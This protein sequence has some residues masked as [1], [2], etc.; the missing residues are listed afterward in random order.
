MATLCQASLSALFFLQH[1]LTSCLCHTLVILAIFQTFSLLLYLLWWCLIRDLW[2]Y[3]CGCFGC[4]N[5]GHL[6]RWTWLLNNTG[7][8]ILH[9]SSWQSN[10]RIW[11]DLFRFLKEALLVGKCYKQT[12]IQ[13][14]VTLFVKGGDNW[15]F[16][17][18]CCLNLRNFHSHAN[19][20]PNHPDQL[21]AINTE[22]RSST[23]KKIMNH[24]RFRW[25][26]PSFSNKVFFN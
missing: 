22:T 2:C 13:A 7:F 5:P 26:L 14:T 9:K 3:C 6:R 25:W 4:I 20:Q 16:K 1:L 15:C 19:L 24:W 11:E 8:R 12:T 17:L 18:H 10:S 23:S 21:E